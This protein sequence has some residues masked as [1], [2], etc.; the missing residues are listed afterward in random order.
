MSYIKMKAVVTVNPEAPGKYPITEIQVRD[1]K[2]G[3]VRIKL[4]STGV[5]H[6]DIAYH[7]DEW[8]MPIA[9]PMVMGHEGAGIVESVGEGVTKVKPGD[10]VVIGDPS[11]GECKFCK[12]GMPWLCARKGD[13]SILYGGKD[14]FGG[15]YIETLDGK[16]IATMFSQGS[17]AEYVLTKETCVTKIPEA[18]DLKLAGPLGCG[19]RAGSGAIISTVKPNPGEWVVVTGGG[20]V[21]MSALWMGKAV[22]AK[23]VLVDIQEPRLQMALDTGADAVVNSKGMTEE[24]TT[25]AI[26]DAMGGEL[27]VGM[28]ECSGFAPAIKA[29]MSACEGGAR[30]AQIGVCGPIS[31]D[32]WFFGPVGS[33]KITFIAMGD[34]SNDD[35]IPK[36]CELYMEGKF[37]F[38]KLVTTYKFSDIQQAMDD[39]VAGKNIKPV[40]LFD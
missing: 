35:I 3:E 9:L 6:T 2:K 27:A 20:A 21:G 14:D 32:S 39:N 4:V 23:V 31:F 22:G 36:L 12:A 10:H 17:F 40:L 24:E 26:I 34:I 30:I 11:C 15:T 19:L 18:M 5:C 8:K 25:Q 16:G 7:T 33:K 38:D 28:V 1:P 37:P 13:T 29:G